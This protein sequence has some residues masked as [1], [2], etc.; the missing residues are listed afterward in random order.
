MTE[1]P[2]P[3]WQGPDAILRRI[4]GE[5]AQCQA[6]LHGLEQAVGPH[7]AGPLAAD[8]SRALQDIDRLGQ[9]LADLTTCLDL[10]A[11]ELEGAAGIDARHLWGAMRL[12]DLA[13]RLGGRPVPPAPP[14]AR[15]ALF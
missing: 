2:E 5:L 3:D 15:V 11:G 9:T 12:D 7:L 4:G 14:D 13:R 8:T 6:M 1:R 10:L